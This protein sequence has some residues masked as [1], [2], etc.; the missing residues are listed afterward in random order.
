[1]RETTRTPQ[2]I[3]CLTYAG[4]T[5]SVNRL[6]GSFI[7]QMKCNYCTQNNIKKYG[8]SGGTVVKEKEKKK[9][10]FCCSKLL[11]IGFSG[12]YPKPSA[13]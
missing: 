13:Q 1:M 6:K 10:T 2:E 11:L 5:R 12:L 9:K 4:Y 3:Q 7:A 8:S